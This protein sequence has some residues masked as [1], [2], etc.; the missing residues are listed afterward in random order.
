MSVRGGPRYDLVTETTGVPISPEAAEM[1]NT[2][3]RY[4]AELAVGKRVLEVGCGSAQG[5]GLIEVGAAQLVGGDL[6]LRLLRLARTH[7]R[8]RF[9][10]VRLRAE[11][12]PFRTDAFDLIL[13]FE[14]SYYLPS[15]ERALAEFTRVLAR[16]GCLAMVNANPER[17]DFIASPHS[18]HYHTADELRTLFEKQG[19]SVIVESAFPLARGSMSAAISVVRKVLSRLGLVPRT[20]R[21][22]AFL[23]RIAYGPLQSLPPELPEGFAGVAPRY[24]RPPGPILD[25]KVIYVTAVRR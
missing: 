16:G 3:Y 1:I 6:D 9:P 24:A 19:W 20:L 18:H 13:L 17:P 4:A 23:K 7:Y 25:F 2:R 8:N 14:S 15:F 21:T 12:L 5:F 11:A 10:L 22:R